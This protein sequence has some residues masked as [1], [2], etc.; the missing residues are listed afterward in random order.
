MLK[1]SLTIWGKCFLKK[2]SIDSDLDQECVA[3]TK[4]IATS[5]LDTFSVLQVV[6]F[7][8]RVWAIKVTQQMRA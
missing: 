3:F 4:Q 2:N 1:R 8:S 5:Y 6:D 7:K